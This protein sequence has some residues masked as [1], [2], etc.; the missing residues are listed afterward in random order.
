MSATTICGDTHTGLGWLDGG[1][2]MVC[3]LPTGHRGMHWGGKDGLQPWP[4]KKGFIHLPGPE[5]LENE[6][7]GIRPHGGF[8][9]NRSQTGLECDLRWGHPGVH[10]RRGHIWR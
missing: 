7:I 4:V 2:T 9:S 3:S 1:A 6:L 8:C 10:A 5:Q